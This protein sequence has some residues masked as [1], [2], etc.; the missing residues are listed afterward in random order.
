MNVL[1]AET[2]QKIG[3]LVLEGRSLRHIEKTLGIAKRTVARYRLRVIDAALTVIKCRCGEPIGHKGWCSA[4]FIESPKRQTFVKDYWERYRI[5]NPR[6]R[7]MPAVPRSPLMRYPYL[8]MAGTRAAGA[9]LLQI[10]NDAVPRY[11]AE[12]VRADICQELLLAIVAGEFSVD[13]VSKFVRPI[14]KRVR[15]RLWDFSAISIDTKDGDGVPLSERIA[16]EITE[17]DEEFHAQ[18]EEFHAGEW[19]RVA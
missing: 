10:V 9:D 11:I 13:E 17:Q 3:A 7:K 5:A 14:A 1:P 4:R 12:D 16:A 18:D 15:E 6:R 19:R 2:V 8:P